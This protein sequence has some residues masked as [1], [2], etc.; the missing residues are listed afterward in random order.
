MYTVKINY[1]RLQADLGIPLAHFPEL[2]DKFLGIKISQ[3]TAYAW[4]S[5]KSMPAER[6]AQLLTIV[7]L[8]SGRRLDIWTYI[9]VPKPIKKAA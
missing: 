7:R 6:L 1:K 3:P 5:R 8:E 9:E 2:F 4:F